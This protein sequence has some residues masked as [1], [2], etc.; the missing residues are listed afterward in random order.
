VVVREVENKAGE[1]AIAK[2][3]ASVSCC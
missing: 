1:L 2:A 3:K